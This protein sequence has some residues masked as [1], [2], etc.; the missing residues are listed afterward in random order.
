MNIPKS[1]LMKRI[2]L[3]SIIGGIVSLYMVGKKMNDPKKNKKASW[4][5]NDNKKADSPPELS[6]GQWKGA[7]KE[8]KTALSDKKLPILAA[9]VAF[10][11]T[12]AFFPILAAGV[13]ILALV[14]EPHQVES[15]IEAVAKFLPSDIASLV[16]AQLK[17]LSG[18]EG[19][20][21]LVATFAILLS[22]YSAS[23]AIQNLINATNTAYD[24][25]ESRGFIKLKL[26]SILLTFGALISGFILIPILLVNSEFLQQ[27]GIPEVLAAI[28]PYARWVLVVAVVTIALAVFYRYGPNRKNPH[29]QWV[30][31]GAAAATLLWLIVTVLFFIYAQNFAKFSGS[32]GVFAG[33]IVLMTWLNISALVFL[34]GAQVNHRLETKTNAP[35]EE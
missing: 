4:K 22:L 31:W 17:N 24:V 29:W 34:I 18:K 27:I 10:F 28:V 20:N 11:S 9:G 2:K 26:I 35:T 16:H 13:S 32:Y 6:K 14:I 23:A 30:S 8:T 1:G 7:L 5:N 33:I 3:F 15:S 12:F 19:A 25:K 21:I